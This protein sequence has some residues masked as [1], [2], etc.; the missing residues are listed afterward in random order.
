[1]ANTINS[2]HGVRGGAA[3][4]LLAGSDAAASTDGTRAA[5]RLH[6]RLRYRKDG[7]AWIIERLAP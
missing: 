2:W 5:N 1:M 3:R 6:D 7:A 4:G